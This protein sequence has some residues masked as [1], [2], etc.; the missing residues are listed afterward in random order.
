[1]LQLQADQIN[2]YYY[3]GG[4]ARAAW[5]R[6]HIYSLI[7]TPLELTTHNYV[8]L[9]NR[10]IPLHCTVIDLLRNSVQDT[11]FIHDMYLI[12]LHVAS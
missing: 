10:S 9:I 7:Q 6:R 8:S 2:S 3:C 4:G 12:H 5:W 11:I 1:M